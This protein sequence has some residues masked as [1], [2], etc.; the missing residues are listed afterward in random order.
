[1]NH[2]TGDR[3]VDIEELGILAN[4]GLEAIVRLNPI[5]LISMAI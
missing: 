2:D 5:V 3:L 1:M 4:S